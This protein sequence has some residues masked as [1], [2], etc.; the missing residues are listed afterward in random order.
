MRKYGENL[1]YKMLVSDLKALEEGI[2]VTKPF[3]KLMKCGLIVHSADNLEA[4]QVGGFS[5]CFSS[6]DICRWCH[7][8]HQDLVDHIHDFDGDAPHSYWNIDSMITLQTVLKKKR[9]KTQK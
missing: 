5:S 6:R 2:Q 8:Q 3:P 4:V 9:K 7:I 1:I